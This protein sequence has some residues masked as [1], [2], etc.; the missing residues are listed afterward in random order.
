MNFAGT[1]T[2]LGAVR[3]RL[4]AVNEQLSEGQAHRSSMCRI[5][6]ILKN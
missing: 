4:R 3:E 6:A 1:D 5:R 2:G